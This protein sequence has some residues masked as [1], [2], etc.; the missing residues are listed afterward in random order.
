[1]NAFDIGDDLEQF[2]INVDGEGSSGKSYVIKVLS[3]Y[4]Q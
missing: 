1:M 4:L 2:L 3:S